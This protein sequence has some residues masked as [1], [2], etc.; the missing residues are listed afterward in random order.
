MTEQ[1]VTIFDF[2]NS[3]SQTKKDIFNDDTQKEYVPYM[4]NFYLAM[5]KELAVLANVMNTHPTVPKRL[6]YLFYKN[7]IDSKK[8]L[9]KY[10]KAADTKSVTHLKKYFSVNTSK[11]EDIAAILPDDVK[12]A[13]TEFYTKPGKGK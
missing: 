13:I 6:Q 7:L 4:I 2:L 12:T 3:V 5:D 10:E 8:R 9:F 11:A 1:K